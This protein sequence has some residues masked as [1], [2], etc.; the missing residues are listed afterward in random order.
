MKY[1]KEVYIYEKD[2]INY[3][4]SLI[5]KNNYAQS[6]NINYDYLVKKLIYTKERKIQ[7][8]DSKDLE[9]YSL[10]CIMPIY[11]DFF[12]GSLIVQTNEPKISSEIKMSFLRFCYGLF[13][14]VENYIL[15]GD[16]SSYRLF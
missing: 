5:Q 11:N 8:L 13:F 16:Y 9:G 2:N 6:K 14:T 12:K 10:R 4:N 7:I 3:S 15:H 1:F